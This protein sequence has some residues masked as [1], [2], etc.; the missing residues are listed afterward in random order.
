MSSLLFRGQKCED[1]SV[2]SKC[3]IMENDTDWSSLDD[4]QCPEVDHEGYQLHQ[5]FEF[6]MEGVTQ[7]VVALLGGIQVIFCFFSTK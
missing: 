1:N 2:V 4:V 7:T 5:S 3:S 6:W